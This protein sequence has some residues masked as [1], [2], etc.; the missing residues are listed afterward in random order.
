MGEEREAGSGNREAQAET[1]VIRCTGGVPTL[2][3]FPLPSFRPY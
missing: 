1:E 2:P 3:D